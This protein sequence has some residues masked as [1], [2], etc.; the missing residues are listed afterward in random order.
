[1]N[2]VAKRLLPNGALLHDYGPCSCLSCGGRVTAT[3]DDAGHE[4]A[5]CIGCGTVEYVVLDND[6]GDPVAG[7]MTPAELRGLP[8]WNDDGAP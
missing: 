1:M 4:H 6:A 8:A 3:H 7:F 5:R 2:N